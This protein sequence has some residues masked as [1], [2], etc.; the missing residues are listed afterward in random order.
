MTKDNILFGIVGLLAGLI[1]GFMFAN[2]VNKGAL[3]SAPTAVA[4]QPGNLPPGHPDVPPGGSSGTGSQPTAAGA[5]EVQAAIEKAKAEPNNF[6]AQ[7][8]AAELYYQ[9]QRFDDA[10]DL[11]KRANHLKPDDYDVV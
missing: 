7:V 2:S 4:G 10:I 9:I 6:D 8:H 5:P 11:L 1:I 3:T